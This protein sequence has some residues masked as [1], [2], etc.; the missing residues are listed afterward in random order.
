MT[1][2]GEGAPVRRRSRGV[3]CRPPSKGPT[4]EWLQ[5]SPP[6]AQPTRKRSGT[7]TAAPDGLWRAT[8]RGVHRRGAAPPVAPDLSGHRTEGRRVSQEIRRFFL[9][10]PENYTQWA[11]ALRFTQ[12]TSPPA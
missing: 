4:G 5:G 10:V 9:F 1:S 12:P 11:S 8:P 3:P 6:K 2:R 7:G